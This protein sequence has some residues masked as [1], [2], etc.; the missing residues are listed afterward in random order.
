MVN[1]L[2]KNEHGRV[3]LHIA[4]AAI[5][6]ALRVPC[7]PAR[8]DGNMA[9]LSRPGATFVTL[10]Q[11]G[12]LRGCIGSLQACDPLIDDVSNNA[13]S[14]ALHDPRFMPLAA[15]ELNAVSVEVSLL[16]ELQALSFRSEADALAQLRPDIDGIVFEC[17]PYR[18]T[19][20]PQVWES[21][22]QPEQFLAK[23][24]SKARLP[25]D[26]WTDDIKLS[27]YTVSKWRETDYTREVAHG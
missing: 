4:R 8:L 9:W 11:R 27:R 14:A 10:T 16:S 1:S 17:G 13:I 25:E 21:L 20:L 6:D 12:E 19:F 3:L 22:S 2:E 24:K 26:F 18:S 23:L 7:A 15:D 5:A